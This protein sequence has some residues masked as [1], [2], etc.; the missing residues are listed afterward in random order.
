MSLE[1]TVIKIKTV[2]LIKIMILTVIYIILTQFIK[3]IQGRIFFYNPPPWGERN[4]REGKW[5]RKSREREGREE[6]CE[7]EGKG[8]VKK[9]KGKEKSGKKGKM[10]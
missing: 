10:S 2:F 6:G 4:Q 3:K 8:K 1:V 5:G 7:M 9:R